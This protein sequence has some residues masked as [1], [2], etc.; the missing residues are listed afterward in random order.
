MTHEQMKCVDIRTVDIDTLV[1]AE[2]FNTNLELP[3]IE[4]MGAAVKHFG[5]PYLFKSGKIAIKVSHADTPATIDDRM[6]SIMR[7]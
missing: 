3:K 7:I 1:D 4:R 2:S 6:E 5:N